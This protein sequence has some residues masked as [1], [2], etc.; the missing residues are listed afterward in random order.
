MID[1]AENMETHSRAGQKV[2]VVG[3]LVN[4]ML[5]IV[6]I[7]G[8]YFG[9]SAALLADGIHSLSDLISDAMVMFA[10][11]HGSQP[12][13][14]D[15]PYGH[16]RIETA[17]TVILGAILAMVAVG[18]AWD[19]V[20]RVMHHDTLVVPKMIVILI[21]ILKALNIFK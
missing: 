2:T 7:I 1:L 11:K 17:A 21:A 19:A 12:A 18:I 8:G 3:A 4:L 13:D 16:A 20:E 10:I 5:S 6:K 15:H 14:E 9:Q